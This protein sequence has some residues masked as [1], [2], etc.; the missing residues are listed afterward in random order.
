MIH[1]GILDIDVPKGSTKSDTVLFVEQYLQPL[2][3]D[4]MKDKN[5]LTLLEHIIG[6][7]NKFCFLN[8]K[9]EF[10]IV[11]EKAGDWEDGVWYSNTSHRY[12]TYTKWWNYGKNKTSTTSASPYSCYDDY[13]YDEEDEFYWETYGMTKQEFLEEYGLT[14]S[15]KLKIKQIIRGL[16]DEQLQEFGEAPVYDLTTGVLKGEHEYTSYGDMFLYELDDELQYLYEARYFNYFDEEE[17]DE[18]FAD[19]FEFTEVDNDLADK[20]DEDLDKYEDDEDY[21]DGWQFLRRHA[22]EFDELND[23]TETTEIADDNE[24]FV[25]KTTKLIKKIAFNG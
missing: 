4:F 24:G 25:S 11:N 2:S 16:T 5:V 10:A 9:G 13:G 1:N 20:E 14:S 3:E 12:A 15:E 22:D 7:T 18:V 17:F 21:Y 8:N 6:S 23:T 19:E